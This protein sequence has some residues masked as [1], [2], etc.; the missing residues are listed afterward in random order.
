MDPHDAILMGL[1]WDSIPKGGILVD[2]GGGIGSSSL[3]IA[4]AVQGLSIVVQDRPNVIEAAKNYWTSEYPEALSTERV[5]LHS[6]DFFAPQ[7]IKDA[8]VFLL[9]FVIHDWAD[10]FAKKI[11]NNLRDSAAPD[12]KLV[13]VDVVVP[14]TCHADI[15]DTIVDPWCCCGGSSSAIVA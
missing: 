7:S 4:R 14:Y 3:L 11:L 10:P 15:T 13:T 9:R 2:V 6:H 1:K 12:T 5:Q 8:S